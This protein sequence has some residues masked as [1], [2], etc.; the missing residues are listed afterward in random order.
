MKKLTK[1]DR[2]N[3]TRGINYLSRVKAP[4]VQAIVEQTK[5]AI[6]DLLNPSL[7]ADNVEL[8]DGL[9]FERQ[10][11]G[12]IDIYYTIKGVK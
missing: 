11:N 1:K 8:R 4:A 10:E 6:S 3:I 9:I 12:H 5:A 2:E 7:D